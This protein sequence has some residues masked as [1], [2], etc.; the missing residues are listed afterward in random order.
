MFTLVDKAKLDATKKAN[1]SNVNSEGESVALPTPEYG[2]QMTQQGFD[3][4]L[5][6]ITPCI[7]SL[8]GK[9]CLIR[10]CHVLH[11]IRYLTSNEAREL[12]IEWRPSAGVLEP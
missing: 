5:C 1:D 8:D 4:Y 12:I 9:L 2:V 11:E 10:G 6:N 3:A 7:F